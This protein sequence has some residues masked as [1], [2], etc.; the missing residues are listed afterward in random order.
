MNE[1]H[2]IHYDSV[3]NVSSEHYYQNIRE[4]KA[5]MERI[6]PATHGMHYKHKESE[7]V[8]FKVEPLLPYPFSR[9]A[10]PLAVADV[11]GDALDDFYV[12]AS[13]DMPG[14]LYVQ[15][16]SGM[17]KKQCLPAS[18]PCHETDVLFFDAD[19][20]GDKDIYNACGGNEYFPRMPNYQDR[21][22]VNDGTGQFTL[23]TSA[24]PD[25]ATSTS[26][27][28]ATDYDLDGDLDLFVGGMIE[29]FRY[30]LPPDSYILQNNGGRFTDITA[31]TC[32][33]LKRFGL[34]KQAQWVD[35]NQDK[36]TD[37]VIAGEYLPITV[38]LQQPHGTLWNA[39]TSLGLAGYVGWWQ[40]VH[41]VDV[42][43][44]GDMDIIAG[45]L[46][47]NHKLKA[48]EAKPLTLVANDFDKNASLDAITARY[49]ASELYPI[50]SRDRLLEQVPSLKKKFL[51][52]R[53]YA[54]TT[55]KQMLDA[56]FKKSYVREATEMR[57]GVF[58]NTNGRFTFV[59]FP[60]RAQGFPIQSIKLHQ[61]SDLCLA[62]GDKVADNMQ[63]N[64]GTG[65]LI[66]IRDFKNCD[67]SS[68][69]NFLFL[70]MRKPI[71][72]ASAIRQHE[73]EIIMAAIRGDSL[74][75][76]VEPPNRYSKSK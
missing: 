40:S 75:L 60:S 58:V 29:P 70:S 39:T 34:V 74:L 33:E 2:T 42:D 22:F 16:S 28:E 31:K 13:S 43:A 71:R 76:L 10:P 37:L 47:L 59:P 49:Y 51:F 69:Q 6:S 7:Y 19:N 24:L 44:D 30:P 52:H 56:E 32:P 15:H 54:K 72:E 62:G 53:D 66:L 50:A 61:D 27:V 21:L 23:A 48:T 11:T 18:I 26:C 55:L 20:D 17:F 1:F 25:F 4:P 5:V 38:F 67:L 3:K 73:H 57:S 64:F 12:G 63:G 8:E 45:N 68:I 46:G 36:K 14:A 35:V 41:T 9:H 65:G